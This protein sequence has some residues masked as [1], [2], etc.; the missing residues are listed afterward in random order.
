MTVLHVD[1]RGLDR[2]D[3]ALVDALA[4]FYLALKQA[5]CELEIRG[6]CDELRDL[7]A[8][9]GLEDVLRVEPRR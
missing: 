7:I 1:V 4:R 2:A 5:G 9:M 3:A 6:A 8:F